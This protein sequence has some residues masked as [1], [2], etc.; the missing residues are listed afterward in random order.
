[1]IK[2]SEAVAITLSG[3]ELVA[4]R[5]IEVEQY[6]RD[7]AKKGERS[8]ILYKERVLTPDIFI[9]LGYDYEVVT[10]HYSSPELGA[11]IIKW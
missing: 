11:L 3:K 10:P 1:M 5:L 4:Q 9:G 6:I 8:I 2:A 7:A